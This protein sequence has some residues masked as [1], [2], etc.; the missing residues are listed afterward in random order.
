MKYFV[1][2]SFLCL[3]N[4]AAGAL[5][6]LSTADSVLDPLGAGR[7]LNQGWWSDG[8]MNSADNSAIQT[9]SINAG[10][11]I[12]YRSFFTFDL[13]NP[14]LAG[15]TVNSAVLTV[16]RGA[17]NPANDATETIELRS[18]STD[19]TL[20]NTTTGISPTIFGDLGSGTSYGSLTV[21]GTGAAGEL[22]DFNL[23][24]AAISDI[25][26]GIGG[27]YFSIAGFLAT[28][29][30]NDTFFTDS[31]AVSAV[32]LTLDV[33]AVPEPTS[34]LLAALGMA[35]CAFYRRRS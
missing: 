26:A 31:P 8:D 11:T 29:D 10:G 3:G 1:L 18:V 9:G 12:N 13:N 2:L 21:A 25:E 15:V 28:S 30:G 33:T 6:V 24:G 23:L 35:G 27:G 34:G 5:V 14:A 16:T 7:T 4:H 19:A 17:G 22:F 32:T 20:L